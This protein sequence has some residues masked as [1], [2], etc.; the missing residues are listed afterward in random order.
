MDKKRGMEAMGPAHW[1]KKPGETKVADGKYAGEFSNPE[2][3]KRSVDALADYA[4]KNR[5]KY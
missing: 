1:E 2:D 3:L 5:M 4:K